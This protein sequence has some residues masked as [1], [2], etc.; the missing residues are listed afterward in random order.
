MVGGAV[1]FAATKETGG[2]GGSGTSGRGWGY[3]IGGL[4][5]DGSIGVVFHGG[6]LEGSITSGSGRRGDVGDI[7]LA[8]T[9]VQVMM[10]P[11]PTSR[12]VELTRRPSGNMVVRPA[13]GVAATMA[14]NERMP[15]W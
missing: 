7:P 15:G 2:R 1:G 6:G 5:G 4:V 13:D 10:T 8:G 11:D 9:C 12:G 3:C 14:G